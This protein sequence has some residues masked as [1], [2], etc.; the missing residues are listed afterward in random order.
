V[1][2]RV[3]LFIVGLVGYGLIFGFGFFWAGLI[4]LTF[5]RSQSAALIAAILGGLFLCW[6]A[7]GL[8]KNII[9]L[10]DRDEST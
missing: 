9:E 6:F 3:T 1:F 2:L 4:V 8:I 10:L 7:R 5:S